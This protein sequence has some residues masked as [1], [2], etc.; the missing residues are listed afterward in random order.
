MN[1]DWGI[2]GIQ[3]IEREV[4][5]IIMTILNFIFNKQWQEIYLNKVGEAQFWVTKVDIEKRES[6]RHEFKTCITNDAIT[7][8]IRVPM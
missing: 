6:Y 4:G 1:L 7:R 8:T 3:F 5:K 2:A